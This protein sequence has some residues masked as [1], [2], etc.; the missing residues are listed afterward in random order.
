MGG[1]DQAAG[2]GRKLRARKNIICKGPGAGRRLLTEDLKGL[3][4]CN[5]EKSC[6]KVEKLN[7]IKLERTGPRACEAL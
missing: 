5:I 6:G 4:A 7:E 3:I 1:R 2:G